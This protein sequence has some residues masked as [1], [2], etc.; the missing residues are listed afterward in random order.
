MFDSSKLVV[1]TNCTDLERNRNNQETAVVIENRFDPA[2]CVTF[3]W[4][5]FKISLPFKRKHAATEDETT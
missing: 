4:H 1:L 2:G 3:A 5:F